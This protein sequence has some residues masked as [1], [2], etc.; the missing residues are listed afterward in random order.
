MKKSNTEQLA[1]AIKKRLEIA[2][3]LSLDDEDYFKDAA[4]DLGAKRVVVGCILFQSNANVLKTF[5]GNP[6]LD[7]IQEAVW[8]LVDR[9]DINRVRQIAKAIVSGN[10]VAVITGGRYDADN[11]SSIKV[12]NP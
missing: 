6:S 7:T 10:K 2:D 8:E 4:A 12:I 11:P 1:S 3:D 9:M 5:I